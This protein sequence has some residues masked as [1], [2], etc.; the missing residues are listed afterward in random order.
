VGGPHSP[1]FEGVGGANSDD[2][3]ES[4][5]L[6]LL[7]GLK[8]RNAYALKILS[9]Q[10]GG[11]SEKVSISGIKASI[12]TGRLYWYLAASIGTEV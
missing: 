7:C 4:L 5:A 10:K 12:G 2:W 6:L 9:S 1:A 8:L 3:R 11:G